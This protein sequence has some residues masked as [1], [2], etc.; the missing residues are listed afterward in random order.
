MRAIA[1]HL[2]LDVLKKATACLSIFLM[3]CS[4]TLAIGPGDVINNPNG[5][6]ITK[7]GNTTTVDVIGNKNVIEWS[8]FNTSGGVTPETLEFVGNGGAKFAV[9]NRVLSGSATQ[10]DGI[11]NAPQGHIIVLNTNG[12]VFGPSAIINAHKFTASGLNLSDTDFMNDYYHFSGGKGAIENNGHIEAKEVALIG[13]KILNN[14]AIVSQQ[15]LIVLATGDTVTLSPED[16]DIIIVVPMSTPPAS[17]VLS[18]DIVNS[19]AGTIDNAGGTIVLA[20]GDVFAQALDGLE[21]R[22]L[23]VEGTTGN[24]IQRGRIEGGS[25]TLSAAKQM[26]LE[27]GSQTIADHTD[28]GTGNLNIKAA[29]VVAREPITA[30]NNMTI[31]ADNS[32]A[33][34]SD[35]TSGGTMTLRAENGAI[36]VRGDLQSGGDMEL[37]AYRYISL[38][39]DAVSGGSM[40]ITTVQGHPRADDT[41]S[42]GDFLAKGDILL[43]TNL[44]L[45][46]GSW[47]TDDFGSVWNGDQRIESTNGRVTAEGFIHK[48]TPGQL[49]IRGGDA[50]LSVDLQY[51]GPEAGVS[52]RGNIYISGVGD[53]Q[54]SGDLT[55]MGAGESAPLPPSEYPAVLP[56]EQGGVSVISR[57]GRIY[58]E[59][60]NAVNVAIEGYSDDITHRSGFGF[61]STTAAG[62]NLPEGE[63]ELGVAAIVLQSKEDLTLGTNASLRAEGI[64]VSQADVSEYGTGVDDRAGV[65]FLDV[66]A[67]IGGADR[68]K[69]IASDVA[70]YA[71]SAKGNVT[72]QTDNIHVNNTSGG[73]YM[74]GNAT[75]VLDAYDTVSMPFLADLDGE[76]SFG[77]FRLEAASRIT[78]WLF[79]AINGGKLPYADNPDYVASIL[80]S[81]YVLRGAG[82][83]NAAIKDGRAWVLENPGDTPDPIVPPL[84][85]L[86]LPKLAGCPLEMQAAAAEL[87][88]PA[89]TLQL[90]IRN[91]LATNPNIQPCD[92][93]ARLVTAAAILSDTD[94]VRLAA[95]NAIFNTLAPADAP[96]TPETSAAIVTAFAQLGE[97]DRQYALAS[98]YIDA[99]VSY[100]A[101]LNDDLKAPIGDPVAF[102]LEKHGAALSGQTVN[103]NA[104]AYILSRIMPQNEL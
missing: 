9:L 73:E 72:V 104:A 43:S 61:N 21:G 65:K 75:V 89:E 102:V 14:G 45:G 40:K 28:G 10:F 7:S 17:G 95:M 34:V 84:P 60:S 97:Q 79:Q 77:G 2:T 33:P 42:L 56:N 78:E 16:S 51:A 82:L 52:N 23:A 66:D 55:G 32:I 62:V 5:A 13:G 38:E 31:L 87:G 27:A 26:R 54:L 30:A 19:A 46:R 67:A 86:E 91:S 41:F 53:I 8:N 92:A 96:F 20:A 25:V 15:G 81:D 94:G 90:T 48:V 69:G 37:L 39:G 3:I 47:Q 63:G 29:N 4:P 83:D 18:G 99:F 80:G 36:S 49:F 6:A 11:L 58:T 57:N 12:I 1:E 100:V 103:P 85:V 68:D 50:D 93:C 44:H 35:L 74:L 24:V 59:D 22:T 101:V 76:S 70:I 98:E 88:I 64:Y 71:G